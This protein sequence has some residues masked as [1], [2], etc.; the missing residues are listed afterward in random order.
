MNTLFEMIK[1]IFGKSKKDVIV[2]VTPAIVVTSTSKPVTYSID[3]SLSYST[4]VLFKESLGLVL[5]YE[6]GY[7]N[8]PNDHGGETNKGIIQ[9]EYDRYRKLNKQEKRSVKYIEDA[10][11]YEI[12]FENYWKAG[13]CS[14]FPAEL[15]IVHF[16]SCVNCGTTQAAKFLQRA[17]SIQADGVIG[18]KTFNA[19]FARLKKEL[20]IF[21]IHDYLD[22]RSQFYYKLVEKDSSQRVFIK[23]WQNR[24][25]R[26]LKYIEER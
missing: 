2:D 14:W 8:N 11:V 26:L 22:Q 16:D 25:S 1:R 7:V 5:K 24:I 23:G 19:L 13:K 12:Y 20:I 9:R 18:T 3:K 4:D 17:I 21:I 6:G 15:A 10:E